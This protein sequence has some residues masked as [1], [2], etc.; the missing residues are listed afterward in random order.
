MTDKNN[1]NREKIAHIKTKAY[2][3]TKKQQEVWD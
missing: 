3:Y 2:L 1:N